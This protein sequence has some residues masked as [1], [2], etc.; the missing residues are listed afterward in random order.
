MLYIFDKDGT[1]CRSKSGRKFINLAEDQELIPGVAEKCTELRASG[2]KLAVA[3]NQ[4]GVAF[5]HMSEDEA[6]FIVAHAAAMISADV[7][8]MC[9]YHIGGSIQAYCRSDFG[10][11][12]NPGMLWAIMIELGYLR[13]QTTFVGDRPEDAE[14]AQNAGVAF[15]WASEFFGWDDAI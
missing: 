6:G 11:K 8:R 2:H 5:G 15:I 1:I 14:A 3:S 9:P 10:R 13:S 4:G 7:W 12:P